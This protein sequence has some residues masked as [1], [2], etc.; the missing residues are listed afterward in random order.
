MDFNPGHSNSIF[1]LLMP[2]ER[3]Q[4]TNITFKEVLFHSESGRIRLVVVYKK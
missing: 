2:V 3:K 4:P 1:L